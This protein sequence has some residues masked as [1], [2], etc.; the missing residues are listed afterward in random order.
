VNVAIWLSLPFLLRPYLPVPK[1]VLG[2][3][4]FW[5]IF[6]PLGVALYQGQSSLLL[7][8]LYAHTYVQFRRGDDFSAG[9]WLGLGLFKFQFVLPFALIFLLRGKWKFLTGLTCS[10]AFLAVLSP[11]AVGWRGV[12]SYVHLLV[13]IGSHPV[14]LSYGSAVDMPTLHGFVYALLGH[15]LSAGTVGFAVAA[16]SIVL[17]LFTAWRW[18]PQD[19]GSDGSFDL[20]F[21]AALTIAL[22]TGSHMFTH[23][24]SPLILALLLACA[25]FPERGR[26]GLRWAVGTTLVLFWTPPL[27]FALVAW[28]QMY[29]MFPVLLVFAFLALWL[30]EDCQQ[31]MKMEG[32]RA[33]N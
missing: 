14:N 26:T 30:A 25:N 9:V 31:E 10:A 33:A 15:R 11:F 4:A 20:R 2:Y 22:I 3:F 19:C 1:E 12:L 27:Y 17:L 23:D 21:A 16:I 32:K 28:H 24:F 7:L 5:L 6:A 29:L 8:A 13:S 18:R